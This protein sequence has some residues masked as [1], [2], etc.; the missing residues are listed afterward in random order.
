MSQEETPRENSGLFNFECGSGTPLGQ[1]PCF[2]TVGRRNTAS[3]I[4]LEAA[5]EPLHR[6]VFKRPGI[7]G[8]RK[9][10]LKGF[11]GFAPEM[12]PQIEE[13]IAAL[14]KDKLR[15][16]VQRLGIRQNIS[17]PVKEVAK[18]VAAFL[19]SPRDDKVI[20][21]SN[22]VVPKRSPKKASASSARPALTKKR[23]R[24]TSPPIP[25]GSTESRSSTSEV[26][27]DTIRV[28]V[29]RRV[30]AM[31]PDERASLGAKAL[32]MELESQFGLPEGGLKHLKED[33]VET[34]TLAVRSL[35]AAEERARTPMAGSQVSIE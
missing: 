25:T 7:A 2:T 9:A 3:A 24:S 13:R 19:M 22:A 15:V 1:L 34:A 8:E 12:A 17:S 30:L 32:R 6:L 4:A 33:I 5:L 26:H 10:A 18:A 23:A 11:R 27:T 14:K 21:P 16:M 28:A 31:H 20:K 35:L 29:F